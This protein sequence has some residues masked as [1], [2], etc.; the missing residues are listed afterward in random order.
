V[1]DKVHYDPEDRPHIAEDQVLLALGVPRYA[2]VRSPLELLLVDAACYVLRNGTNSEE[3]IAEAAKSYLM[4][5]FID[6]PSVMNDAI[7]S[8]MNF[9]EDEGLQRAWS[10]A[11]QDQPEIS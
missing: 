5:L 11:Q 2:V 7:F 3:E 6:T 4:A 9:L 1:F 10:N 8:C